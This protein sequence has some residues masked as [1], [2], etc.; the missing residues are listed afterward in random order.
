MK[1]RHG[2]FAG[3]RVMKTITMSSSKGYY[4]VAGSCFHWLNYSLMCILEKERCTCIISGLETANNLIQRVPSWSSQDD[5]R[6][7][8]KKRK[9]ETKSHCIATEK[10]IFG[11]KKLVYRA[12]LYVA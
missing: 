8:S 12:S 2:S 5:I 1:L 6:D 4:G 3:E 7:I 9:W 11:R 10:I